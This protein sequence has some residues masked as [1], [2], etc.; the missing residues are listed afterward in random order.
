MERISPPFCKVFPRRATCECASRIVK[1]LSEGCNLP[2]QACM[3]AN[4]D[5]MVD[6]KK[7]LLPERTAW[8]RSLNKHDEYN[9]TIE[10]HV[11]EN[12]HSG[13]HR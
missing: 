8:S 5:Q 1:N 13:E 4:L 7:G 10:T 2:H 6:S 12:S 11:H 3:S 9:T